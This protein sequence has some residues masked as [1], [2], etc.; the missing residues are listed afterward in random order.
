MPYQGQ[1]CR[2]IK[3]SMWLLMAWMATLWRRLCPAM[4]IH[5][6]Q[7]Y[8]QAQQLSKRQQ[9]CANPL[10]LIHALASCADSPRLSHPL[11]SDVR[12]SGILQLCRACHW[13]E[14]A[15]GQ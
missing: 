5:C 7:R 12:R 13:L 15:S 14:L 3:A 6:R 4:R 1:V 9:I 11:T 8:Q 2:R 10:A